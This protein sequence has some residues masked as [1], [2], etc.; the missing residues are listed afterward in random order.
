MKQLWVS[1]FLSLRNSDELSIRFQGESHGIIK[2]RMDCN[3]AGSVFG[4]N[5][6]VKFANEDQLHW[7]GLVKRRLVTCKTQNCKTMI[8]KT[9][10]SL[11]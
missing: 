1:L 5:R 2:S 7:T 3:I 9:R 8:R 6:S 4:P 10:T 11:F